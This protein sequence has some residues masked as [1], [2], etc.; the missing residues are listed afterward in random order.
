MEMSETKQNQVLNVYIPDPRWNDLYRIGCIACIV[1]AI[2][3]IIA[4]IIFFIWPYKPG[5][6]TVVDIFDTLQNDRLGGLI[7]LDL[8]VPI[9]TSI[10]ILQLLALYASLKGVNESYALIALVLGLAE[11][12][13]FLAV[14][15]LAEMVYLSDQYAA[16]TNEIAKSQYLAAGEAIHA[17]FNGTGWMLSQCLIPTSFLISS[18]LMLRSNIFSKAT[19]YLGLVN[20][21]F[22]FGIL[23][24]VFVITAVCGLGSTIGSVIWVI[25]IARTF[26]HLGWSRT[27]MEVQPEGR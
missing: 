2:M 11:C 21:I 3:T 10:L 27:D 22:A 1:N 13:L 5:F 7:S 15:P 8:S 17:L 20:S 23:I 14:R 16:A 9:I 24:P 26:F 19:A 4:V 6:T 18:L 12:I 25:L